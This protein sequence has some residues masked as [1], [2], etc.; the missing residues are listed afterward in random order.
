MEEKIESIPKLIGALKQ[1]ALKSSLH[2]L[3]IPLQGKHTINSDEEPFD[4]EDSLQA[5]F[6]FNDD[7]TSDP[8]I[9]LLL[10]DAGSGKSVFS[11]QLHQQL[12]IA[13]Q[14]G[15]P[16]PLWIPLPELERPFEG[17]VEEVLSRYEFSESKIAELKVKERFIFVVD[18]YDELHHFQNCY[19][20]NHWEQWQAKILMTCRSQALYNKTDYEKYFMPYRGEKPLPLLM[21]K[22]YVAPFSKEQISAYLEKYQQL[23]AAHKISEEDFSLIPELTELIT[24]PFMLHLAVESLPDILANQVAD[25]ENQSMTQ[26]K[27]YDAF[28]ERWFTRQIAKLRET[29][30]V[31]SSD[32]NLKKQFWDYCKALAT[33]MHEKQI[34]VIPYQSQKPGGRLFGKQESKSPWEHFFSA[35]TEIVRSACPLK[36]YGDHQFG[37][38]HASLVNYFNNRAMYEIGKQADQ[39]HLLAATELSSSMLSPRINTVKNTMSLAD[40]SIKDQSSN[41]AESQ[42]PPSKKQLRDPIHHRLFTDD[43]V[44]VRL[45]A[46]RVGEEDYKNYLL[47]L[48]EASKKHQRYAIGAANAITGLVKAG[49]HFNRASLSGIRIRGANISG[50][51]FDGAD[52]T[53][54]DLRDV[55]AKNV[56]LRGASIKG[57]KVEGIDFGEYPWFMHDSPVVCFDYREDLQ[58]MA[59]ACEKEIVLW[60]TI[61]GEKLVSLG[62]D[63]ESYSSVQFSPD[64]KILAS[65][66]YDNTVQFWS[67]NKGTEL[68]VLKGHMAGVICIAFNSDGKQL[69]SGSV[70]NTIRLWW[71]ERESEFGVLKGHESNVTCVTFSPDDKQVISG[72][73]DQTVRIW[74]IVGLTEL[75][76]LKCDNAIKCLAYS[77]CGRNVA[78]GYGLSIKIWEVENGAC[79]TDLDNQTWC[80]SLAFNSIGDR[81]VVGNKD[82]T[83][84]I[85]EV[86]NK[87]ILATMRGHTAPVMHVHF[88]S[89]DKRVISGSE[90]KTVRIWDIPN[91]PYIVSI[92]GHNNPVKIIQFSPDGKLA[93]SSVGDFDSTLLFWDV[94]LGKELMKLQELNATEYYIEGLNSI[95]FSP[96]GKMLACSGWD[97]EVRIWDANTKEILASLSGGEGFVYCA[98]F[99]P[100]SK[101]IASGRSKGIDIWEIM[102]RK[103]LKK[104]GDTL[105][106][107]SIVYSRDGKRIL[108][109]SE[110][111]IV[112][113]W[114]VATEKQL[115]KFKIANEISR[116][117][118]SPD[119]RTIMVCNTKL[120]QLQI[121]DLNSGQE[122]SVLPIG[123]ID[124]ATQFQFINDG[125]Y[126]IA[127]TNGISIQIWDI[128]NKVCIN[129]L[130]CHNKVTCFSFHDN[131]SL[132]IGF[133]DNSL[134]CWQN[135]GNED[136]FRWQLKWTTAMESPNLYV[137]EV[138]A[139]QVMDM[140]YQNRQLLKQRGAK[141]VPMAHREL[142]WKAADESSSTP[143]LKSP[144][145]ITL[146]MGFFKGKRAVASIASEDDL[147]ER[148]YE[149]PTYKNGP[150]LNKKTSLTSTGTIR[151]PLPTLPAPATKPL[152]Q[153]L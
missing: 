112:Q 81:L 10:G 62:T 139:S 145:E 97:N 2:E 38:V 99:S 105:G 138:D 40:D 89:N 64:G 124:E 15:D 12:C 52:I 48:I 85:L 143:T 30:H 92:L 23:N 67:V 53:K 127:G 78:A 39:E 41:T 21:R 96:N 118:F 70:D 46:D 56:W 142:K 24:S 9:M 60:D 36:R 29:S 135:I 90:D 140:N 110:D 84:H 146:K 98:Q 136:H 115:K 113:I 63:T 144:R 119:E 14:L 132:V 130:R 120:S 4:L 51:F 106:I 75:M 42:L 107:R 76:T 33:L 94:G 5:F 26:A 128:L 68:A 109:G 28:I 16:I 49:V 8:K 153:Y 13:Y 102:N 47:K 141:E 72:S 122:I 69:A 149:Q 34:S 73:W 27:L 83:V 82:H 114:E 25:K 111:G 71:V 57:S 88:C 131:G 93:V 108:T 79:I 116:A 152:A 22:T 18:G 20:T 121:F 3:Y 6:Q 44:D 66:N 148:S 150:S 133:S 37:F 91:V 43:P 54:A 104:I 17:A 151:K 129:V 11:Q 126:V 123:S 95:S 65:G 74:D 134:Q 61:S 31:K 50:G 103:L 77:P 19:V 87:K 80:E 125:K 86:N 1:E 55:L 117:R 58:R 7:T 59:T 100:D 32:Q 137:E 101:F 45:L 147:L 35:E